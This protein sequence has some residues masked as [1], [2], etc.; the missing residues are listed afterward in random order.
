MSECCCKS[1]PKSCQNTDR[2]I[3][4]RKPG[5]FYSPS[6][7]VT[8]DG[9]I[10]INC[11]G[12]VIVMPIERW[13]EAAALVMTSSPSLPSWRLRLGMWLLQ[14]GLEKYKEFNL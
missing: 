10:G 8:K 13:H 9:G 3:W 1:G 5:D 12:T 2:E 11:R 7:H 6:I 4:R 14:P